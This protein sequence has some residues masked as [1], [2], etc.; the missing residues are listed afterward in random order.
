MRHSVGKNSQVS[1]PGGLAQAL[2][3]LIVFPPTLKELSNMKR[4]MQKGFTLIELMI[5]I[6][7]I[8]ILAAIALPQYQNYTIRAKV[9]EALAISAGAKLAVAETAQSVGGLTLITTSN[10]GYVSG[11]SPYTSGVTIDVSGGATSGTVTVAVTTATGAS[12]G[13]N[14]VL[15]PT[16]NGNNISW[17]CTNT[18]TNQAWV[19]ATC[20]S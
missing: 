12:A 15:T 19:P 11:S 2:Q 7:I 9:S 6:A 8:G 3:L 17:A 18:A 10:H 14:I 4:Q 16:A 20:R 5:V 1:P 13:F